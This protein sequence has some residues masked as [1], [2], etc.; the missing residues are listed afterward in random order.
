MLIG[1][2]APL[3]ASDLSVR[4]ERKQMRIDKPVW[5]I[6]GEG[7]TGVVAVGPRSV[8]QCPG[9]K[10]CAILDYIDAVTGELKT[11]TVW[12]TSIYPNDAGELVTWFQ[13]PVNG[14][15]LGVRYYCVPNRGGPVGPP[16]SGFEP[17]S[18]SYQTGPTAAQAAYLSA[19]DTDTCTTCVPVVVPVDPADNPDS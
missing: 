19:N 10:L 14:T 11:Q 7:G 15:I 13:P 12:V 2:D 1:V 9:G 18:T 5:Q 16:P 3:N 17:T 4:T 8:P 6:G